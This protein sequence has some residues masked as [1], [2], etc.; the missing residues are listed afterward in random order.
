ME[1]R[2]WKKAL[3]DIKYWQKTGNKPVQKKITELLNDIQKTPYAG[4]GKPEG[5]KH[6]L[7]GKWS[8][9]INEVDRLVYNIEDEAL[10]VYS[11]KGHYKDL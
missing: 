3:E 2:Y 4:L 9:K 6:G 11:M 10:Q 5:L 7:S 1:I 8:R